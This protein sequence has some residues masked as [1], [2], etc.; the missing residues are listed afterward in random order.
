MITALT[1]NYNTP[2]LLEGLLI[3]FRQFYDIP[4]TVVDG[5]DEYNF[6]K[7]KG[8][9]E[10]YEIEL[11]HFNYNVHHGPGLAWGMQ[12][13]KTEQILLLDSDI[14]ILNNMAI[15]NFKANLRAESYGIGGICFVNDIGMNI[16]NG[17]KYLHPACAL[18]N[19]EVA[20]RYPLPILHGAPMI[21]T[22][23][24]IHY[25]KLDILQH[26]PNIINSIAHLG[27]GT[28]YS[29]GGLHL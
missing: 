18:L 11:C 12:H 19:R 25:N 6:E 20:L 5:S 14:K 26:E 21:N 28:V 10:K 3:S 16:I 27:S 2:E 17:M 15:E 29:T 13:I 24:H 23:V 9:P 4:Y 7:I 1:V 22:M 8:F